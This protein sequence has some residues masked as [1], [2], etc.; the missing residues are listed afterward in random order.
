MRAVRSPA[1]D[2]LA[3]I[4]EPLGEAR[5]VVGPAIDGLDVTSPNA[6]ILDVIGPQVVV[7]AVVG[8]TVVAKLELLRKNEALRKLVLDV[9]FLTN[10]CGVET[11][12]LA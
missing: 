1:I 9:R 12:D 11:P 6:E 2:P 4:V 5:P 10:G 8:A 3:V 7:R